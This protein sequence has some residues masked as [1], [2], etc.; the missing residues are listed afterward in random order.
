MTV[1]IQS[2]GTGDIIIQQRTDDKDIVFQSDDGSGGVD[3]Y[4]RLDGSIESLVAYKDLLMAVDGNGGK[5]KFGASQDL[6]IYPRRQ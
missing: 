5:L 6:Q 2:S 4:L 3:T 1:I